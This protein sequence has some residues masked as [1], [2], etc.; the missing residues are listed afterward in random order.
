MKLQIFYPIFLFSILIIFHFIFYGIKAAKNNKKI[1]ELNPIN[2]LENYEILEISKNN[3]IAR[4]IPT[5]EYIYFS[6]VHKKSFLV[7]SPFSS[8]LMPTHLEAFNRLIFF[9]DNLK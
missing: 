7:S 9:I 8:E 1:K 2:L 6:Q 3:F 5:K 4:Y